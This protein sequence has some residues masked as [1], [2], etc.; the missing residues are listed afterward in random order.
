MSQLQD[1]LKTEYLGKLKV[2]KVSMSKSNENVIMESLKTKQKSRPL[3]LVDQETCSQF[4]FSPI[5]NFNLPT[6]I[7]L[8]LV[9]QYIIVCVSL[10]HCHIAYWYRVCACK[11][12]ADLY[13]T[14]LR[15]CT[16]KT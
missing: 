5:G 7:Y 12:V 2:A 10:P 13:C 11:F 6:K 15:S 8:C 3:F 9:M 14:I 1:D 4:K 16:L